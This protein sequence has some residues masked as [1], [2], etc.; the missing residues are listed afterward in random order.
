MPRIKG[1]S[2][3]APAALQ[4]KLVRL[5]GEGHSAA[6]LGKEHGISKNTIV[7]WARRDGVK[8]GQFVGSHLDSEALYALDGEITGLDEQSPT[9]IFVRRREEDAAGTALALREAATPADAYRSKLAQHGLRIL[10]S[11]LAAP[12]PCRTMADLKR[13]TEILN[14]AFG[15]GGRNN[16]PGG[17]LAIDLTLLTKPVSV[18]IDA[19]IIEKT[20]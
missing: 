15:I 17:K 12:P 3:L 5:Y 13:L 9:G 2:N 1:Q 8:S 4:R 10:D 20:G 11:A 16:G 18:T 19:E 14:D 6:A 7:Y